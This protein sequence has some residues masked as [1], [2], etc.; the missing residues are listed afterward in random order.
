MSLSS[1]S[2]CGGSRCACSQL[3]VQHRAA[4]P[5]LPPCLTPIP[6]FPP[7]ILN[8][9]WNPNKA[10]L[11]PSLAIHIDPPQGASADASL[12]W[13]CFSHLTNDNL[14]QQAKKVTVT[15]KPMY[16]KVCLVDVL[17]S[18]FDLGEIFLFNFYLAIS[19]L[20]NSF[21]NELT[22]WQSLFWDLLQLLPST[23][24]QWQGS[25]E[26]RAKQKDLTTEESFKI[27]FKETVLLYA[28]CEEL[29]NW[30]TVTS[31]LKCFPQGRHLL[32]DITTY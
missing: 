22:K 11:H 15:A 16:C 17:V 9:K 28:V 21:P 32:N 19:L 5:Y 30:A 24:Q 10:H 12:F 25:W 3:P 14:T 26:H 13:D 7:I 4:L 1:R 29:S 23:K 8:N 6:H 31:S 27:V 20:L 2:S 18:F